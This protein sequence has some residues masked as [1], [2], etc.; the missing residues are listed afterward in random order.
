M[1]KLLKIKAFLITLVVG[2]LVALIMIVVIAVCGYK[3][4]EAYINEQANQMRANSKVTNI[5]LIMIY[6]FQHIID[7]LLP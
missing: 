7:Y 1:G 4:G 5:Y 2:F 3:I 6:I